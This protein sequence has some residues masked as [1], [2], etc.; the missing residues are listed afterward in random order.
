MYERGKESR[1]EMP[2]AAL[3]PTSG[4]SSER[5]YVTLSPVAKSL[6]TWHP[7]A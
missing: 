4:C 2:S 7:H 1:D 5:V 3:Q 6:L